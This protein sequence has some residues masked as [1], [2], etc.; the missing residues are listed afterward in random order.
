M[1]KVETIHV[2]KGI[3]TVTVADVLKWFDE[4]SNSPKRKRRGMRLTAADVAPIVKL[5]NAQQHWLWR[6]SDPRIENRNAVVIGKLRLVQS[7]IRT[8]RDTLPGILEIYRAAGHEYLAAVEGALVLRKDPSEAALQEI[9]EAIQK[10]PGYLGDPPVGRP[11]DIARV[12]AES[13]ADPIQRAWKAAGRN[14]VSFQTG[15]GP[16]ITVLCRALAAITGEQHQPAAVVS[17]LKRARRRKGPAA[18]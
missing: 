12:L 1:S 8:L 2:A 13:L 7:A 6:P 9:F 15:D 14:Q 17:L 18:S 5:V 11:I 16:G 4:A 10:A 3:A